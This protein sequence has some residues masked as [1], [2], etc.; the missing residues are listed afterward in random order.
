MRLACTNSTYL[1][2]LLLLS[3][4]PFAASASGGTGKYTL[5][6]ARLGELLEYHSCGCA[7]ACWVAEVRA[8]TSRALLA[9]LRCDCEN[10]HFSIGAHGKE[11]ADIRSCSALDNKPEF[12]RETLEKLVKK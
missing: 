7:D 10:L 4:F 5:P 2:L 12:I 6:W 1:G 11:Q 8:V 9:K 3:V